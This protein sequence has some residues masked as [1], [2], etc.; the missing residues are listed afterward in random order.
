MKVRDMPTD[1][2]V[3]LADMLREKGIRNPVVISKVLRISGRLLSKTVR[4]TVDENYV[5]RLRETSI[6]SSKPILA[7]EIQDYA[8]SHNLY[9]DMGKPFLLKFAKYTPFNDEDLGDSERAFRKVAKLIDDLEKLRAERDGWEV[10]ATVSMDY[11]E[12]AVK[13]LNEYLN[14]KKMYEEM[15]SQIPLCSTCRSKILRW[16]LFY[17]LIS[18]S[19]ASGLQKA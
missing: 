7:K 5:M 3:K 14:V 1:E 18:K 10:L 9:H 17:N 12:K 8:W 19:Q 13:K 2:K 4:G 15:L 6:Q 16:I 11:L